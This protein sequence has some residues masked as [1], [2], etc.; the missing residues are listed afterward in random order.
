MI[1]RGQIDSAFRNHS[2]E[3]THCIACGYAITH[4]YFHTEDH[5]LSVMYLPTSKEEAQ[6]IKRFPMRFN[7][8]ARC[9][10]VFNTKFSYAQVPYDSNSNL[11]YNK[12]VGWRTYIRDLL[13]RMDRY[14]G[15]QGKTCIEIGCGDG[16]FMQE[17]QD[18]YQAECIGFEPGTEQEYA[19]K[20]GLNV[21]K[22]YFVPERDLPKYN[23]DMMICRHVLEHLES[24]LQFVTDIAYWC[25][26]YHLSPLFLVEVPRIDK[27]LAQGRVNDYL[28]E[29]VSNFTDRSFRQMFEQAGYDIIEQRIAYGDEVVVGLVRPKIVPD[30]T[31]HKESAS[32]AIDE[33]PVQIDTIHNALVELTKSGTVALWGGTGKSSAFINAFKVDAERFPTV[34]DS[35]PNKCGFFVPGMGQE[36]RPPDYL[37]EQPADHIIITTQ[38][39]AKD[40]YAEITERKIPHKACYAIID[41]ELKPYDGGD[42]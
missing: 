16:G 37:L 21:I 31:M 33:L 28:Y 13:A 26:H 34:I 15:W 8:C 3:N 20:N 41:Q 42:I 25:A 17:M 9:G 36:I 4:P 38:W 24:P 5:P 11:M 23:P 30:L 14:Y 18:T 2:P 39:R 32:D 12:G 35:D 6:S 19:V 1:M 10:H 27:A 40:I 29:H 7:M 22:D